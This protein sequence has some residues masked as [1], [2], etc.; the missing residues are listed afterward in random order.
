MFNSLSFSFISDP[1]NGVFSIDSATGIITLDKP[2]AI[3]VSG[4]EYQLTVQATA[5]V[6][7]VDGAVSQA[8]TSAQLSISIVNDTYIYFPTAYSRNVS[9]NVKDI[10]ILI[11]EA[12]NIITNS[13]EDVLYTL[14]V[15]STYF[16]LNNLTGELLLASPLDRETQSQLII[17][18]IASDMYN[19]SIRA[20][21]DVLISVLDLNDVTPVCVNSTERHITG[22]FF[23]TPH[24]LSP[25]L[26]CTDLDAES[27]NNNITFSLLVSSFSN[28]SIDSAN[29]GIFGIGDLTLGLHDLSVVVSDMGA[30][31]GPL[32]TTVIVRLHVTRNDFYPQF[33]NPD[34]SISLLENYTLIFITT[35][36]VSDD[37]VGPPGDVTISYRVLSTDDDVF[38]VNAT[39]GLFSLIASLDYERT[40]QYIIE[41]NATDDGR[42]QKYNTTTL[43]LNVVNLND[44]S[45]FCGALPTF[46]LDFDNS[47]P[48]FLYQLHCSDPDNLTDLL[49][50]SIDNTS[51][52]SIYFSIGSDG[53]IQTIS[54]FENLSTPLFPVF[55]PI[56]IRVGEDN[57]NLISNFIINV[58]LGESGFPFEFQSLSPPS[59]PENSLPGTLVATFTALHAPTQLNLAIRYSIRS[60]SQAEVFSLDSVSGQLRLS[61]TIDFEIVREYNISV[62]AVDNATYLNIRIFS[63]VIFVTDICDN[64]PVINHTQ[65]SASVLQGSSSNLAVVIHT[66]PCSDLD[67]GNNGVVFCSVTSTSPLIDSGN[68]FFLMSGC[69]LI[70][71][72]KLNGVCEPV[73]TL[74]INCTDLC[75]DISRRTSSSFQFQVQVEFENLERPK[76]LPLSYPSFTNLFEDQTLPKLID[77]SANNFIDEDC[78]PFNQTFFSIS[79]TPQGYLTSDKF[80]GRIVLNKTVDYDKDDVLIAADHRL[81]SIVNVF[82]CEELLPACQGQDTNVYL[83]HILDVNDNRPRCLSNSTRLTIP[84][85]DSPSEEYPT[86][87]LCYDIDRSNQTF[88]MIYFEIASNDSVVRQTFEV[89]ST[90]HSQVDNTRR[91]NIRLLQSLDYENTSQYV[92][93]V[94]ALDG[95]TPPLYS[96]DIVTLTI[97]VA[98]INEHRPFFSSELVP[99]A[100][101]EDFNISNIVYNST[102]ID[103]D[104]APE[105]SALYQ[106]SV[107]PD[108]KFQINNITGEITLSSSLD[109]EIVDAYLL[110]V[111][112]TE[113]TLPVHNHTATQTIEVTVSDINDNPP[114]LILPSSPIQIQQNVSLGEIHTFPCTDRDLADNSIFLCDV[115]SPLFGNT[116]LFV[117]SVESQV[118]KLSVNTSPAP[119]CTVALSHDLDINCT[120]SGTPSL[121]SAFSV[122]VVVNLVNLQDPLVSLSPIQF[123]L[124]ES[125]T[126]PSYLVNISQFVSD[127]DCQNFGQLTFSINSQFPN[128]S[129]F[130]SL[131]AQG[132]LSLVRQVDF[133]DPFFGSPPS[134][135]LEILVQDNPGGSPM[136]ETKFNFTF[137]IQDS[138]DNP[139]TCT[140]NSVTVS[141]EEGSLSSINL[142]TICSDI[143]STRNGELNMTFSSDHATLFLFSN[144]P[145]NSSHSLISIAPIQSLDFEATESYTVLVSITDSG[146]PPLS[147]TISVT[148]LVININDNTPA[149]TNIP[150]TLSVTENAS[151]TLLFTISASDLDRGIFGQLTYSLISVGYNSTPT[152]IDLSVGNTSQFEVG[153]FSGEL[154][155]LTPV[156]FESDFIFQFGVLVQDLGSPPEVAKAYFNITVE[157]VNEFA[158]QI[159]APSP[160]TVL[161]GAAIGTVVAFVGVTDG[162]RGDTFS[163]YIHTDSVPP[164]AATLFTLNHTELGV[165]IVLD[166]LVVCNDQL[167][168]QLF[169]VCNDSSVN[170]LSSSII[171]NTSIISQN[172]NI[173]VTSTNNISLV[174]K[175]NEVP[176]T[177]VF[178]VSSI[179]F[180]PDCARNGSYKY[181]I[182]YQNPMN[183]N[184]LDINTL[185]GDVFVNGTI[186][187]ESEIIV[188]IAIQVQDDLQTGPMSLPSPIL[189]TATITDLNDN[190]PICNTNDSFSIPEAMSS[191]NISTSILCT[192]RDSFTNISALLSQ[193]SLSSNF[194][195][196]MIHILDTRFQLVLTVTNLDYEAIT[197]YDLLIIILDPTRPEFNQTVTIAIE[198]LSVNEFAPLLSKTFISISESEPL[199]V[200]AEVHDSVNHGDQ[201]ESLIYSF[202]QPYPY[203]FS[204]NPNN[205]TLFLNTSLDF[206]NPDHRTIIITIEV[207]DT[208]VPPLS[209]GPK[210]FTITLSDANDNPPRIEYFNNQDYF[211][212]LQSQNNVIVA[213][214]S[215]SDAD[216]NFVFTRFTCSI[217][218]STNPMI[219][220]SIVFFATI[221]G[222]ACLIVAVKS[223]PCVDELVY[224]LTLNCQDT[225]VSTLFSSFDFQIHLVP[226]NLTAPGASSVIFPIFD[227]GISETQTVTSLPIVVDQT[228]NI[229]TSITDSDCGIFGQIFYRVD[230]LRSNNLEYVA[231]DNKTGLVT[232]VREVD[233]EV[234]KAQTGGGRINIFLDVLDN[235]GEPGFR[236]FGSHNLIT[237][238]ILDDNDEPPTCDKSSISVA[239]ME[240]SSA[241]FKIPGGKIICRDNDSCFGAQIQAISS[242]PLFNLSTN[243]PPCVNDSTVIGD[244]EFEIQTIFRY[245]LEV[246]K[247]IT[248]LSRINIT[249]G[250]HTLFIDVNIT[251][252]DKQEF[253]LNFT[254]LPYNLTINYT[255][256]GLLEF[257]VTAIDEDFT[258]D[259]KY[260][261]IILFILCIYFVFSRYNSSDLFFS[262]DPLSG[263]IS[264]ISPLIS[265]NR[266][267]FRVMVT[268]IELTTSDSVTVPLDI[269]VNHP[270]SFLTASSMFC[271]KND[272]FIY[273]NYTDNNLNTMGQDYVRFYFLN[274]TNPPL[275][276][277]NTALQGKLQRSSLLYRLMQCITP[278]A[279]RAISC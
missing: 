170:S 275:N 57:S 270:P 123:P 30:E 31:P 5:V 93:E 126:V 242:D 75:E 50:F 22:H 73:F 223:P 56:P 264:V 253:R 21:T 195:V 249:D 133:D 257:S 202:V 198:I 229:A 279:S 96:E 180:D 247:Q 98:N 143:D 63:T 256:V 79:H 107:T 269:I 207:T 127:G 59:L 85:T 24:L 29:G 66:F 110:V 84:E 210:N 77:I 232:I 273:L 243:L 139:P 226:E 238:D 278:S 272:T 214:L 171:F 248:R 240:E 125:T 72:R 65:P 7:S 41:F 6:R 235:N 89:F 68:P 265:T 145:I 192:D 8:V 117:F 276:F 2:L 251:I 9:E 28:L 241:L 196:R 206:E 80:E 122:T 42:P 182:L 228:S 146:T 259:I 236:T 18:V 39:T 118:C 177:V 267:T 40:R 213:N 3:S 151:P 94:R 128:G 163:C 115:T 74:Q 254:G 261:G 1:T 46:Y 227:N 217:D 90:M 167:S 154:I 216:T 233:K 205:G 109:R 188:A 67:A 53:T 230:T 120:D 17:P 81:R 250:V 11:V 61:D 10:I 88:G 189:L 111:L 25:P 218:P 112:A 179:L 268:A 64:P 54:S 58:F 132:D 91:L 219:F 168:Y 136:R 16:Q 197:S 34:L 32:S 186:D 185:S 15:P 70:L 225:F 45:P 178:Q 174:I 48:D 49:L 99:I 95:G 142:S 92:I 239:L 114:T 208:G 60:V 43:I 274:H 266:T 234:L 106:L 113:T 255:A 19:S 38:A 246:E 105:N 221:S 103:L 258:S 14:L 4:D 26:N 82:D 181:S 119:N 13:S 156:D 172:L 62:R 161:Q 124:S 164:L 209:S 187:Y 108:E 23:A 162:D 159:T 173:P 100:L 211:E 231:V 130:V 55:L 131:S 121:S 212:V 175:E 199:G 140:D 37:D 184:Y 147:T 101:S 193:A 144:F 52:A 245:N 224:N 134:L 102:V 200:V 201:N 69:D 104:H 27:P 51:N 76:V 116:E 252:I 260:G 220:G 150:T 155:Q 97:D 169:I 277:M 222:P 35:I 190:P 20:R 33:L 215:C 262:V 78:S 165:F 71:N 204:L 160:G 12:I 237:I 149:F 157:N 129:L 191:V 141:I 158:P 166:Q 194:S 183:H 203:A 152:P 138:N 148:V 176:N 47:F 153:L 36:L 135:L 44:E 263:A 86:S 271:V 83:V 87:V 137:M 244:E